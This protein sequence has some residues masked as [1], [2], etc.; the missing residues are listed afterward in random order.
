MEFILYALIGAIAG[1]LGGLL[2]IGGG[3]VVVPA[4]LF[5][6]HQMHFPDTYAMQI[7]VGTSLGAMLFTSASSAW[8]HYRQ[9]GVS[10][11]YVFLLAPG[12]ILG[13]ICGAISADYISSHSLRLIFAISV[14]IIGST[15]IL[16][17][18][19]KE[20]ARVIP[21]NTLI[22]TALGLFIGALSSLLGIGGG[23]ITVPILTAMQMPI[24]NAIS[25]SAA[26]GF[27]IAF[28]GALAFLFLGLRHPTDSGN[29]GYLYLP[30][31]IGIGLTS[32]I[33]APL[34]AKLAYTWPTDILRRIFGIVLIIAGLGMI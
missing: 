29:L 20:T 6:F 15:F 31:F 5:S 30:A 24:R 16:P 23:I 34:G 7:A 33:A 17:A 3:L 25:T 14:I 26:I 9:K 12:V 8:A 19:Q 13:A 18:K 32:C 4:L 10:W 22:M 27:V 1:F 2:G 21:K 11:N 28:I